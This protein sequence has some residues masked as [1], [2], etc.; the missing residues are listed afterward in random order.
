MS[1]KFLS[2]KSTKLYNKTQINDSLISK[3]SDHIEI[4]I[5]N[6]SPYFK[7]EEEKIREGARI[8]LESGHVE[9]FEEGIVVFATMVRGLKYVRTDVDKSGYKTVIFRELT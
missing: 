2:Q 3:N 6:Q 5:E 8:W 4:I 1:L 9:S 7:N